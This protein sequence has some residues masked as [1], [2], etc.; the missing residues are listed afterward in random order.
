VI[1]Q[2]LF[3]AVMLAMALAHQ[4]NHRDFGAPKTEIVR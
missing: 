3:V 1:R 4:I 2:F